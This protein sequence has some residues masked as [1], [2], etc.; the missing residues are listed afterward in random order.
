M[1]EKKLLY[2][3]FGEFAI[4]EAEARLEQ[5]GRPVELAPRAFQVL[6]EL[7]RRAGKLVT[8][9]ALL[10][11]VWGHRHVNEAALKNI[12]S[13]LRHALGDDAR[14]S[15]FIETVA[16]RGYRFIA[17]VTDTDTEPSLAVASV[18]PSDVGPASDNP[19]VGRGAV[20]ER[21]QAAVR[22][23]RSGQRQMVFVVGEA[24]I[25]KSALV[26]R[27]IRDAGLAVAFGQCIEHYGEA[28]PYMPVLEA[29]NNLCRTDEA[30]A[31]IDLMRRVAPTW[32]L[33]L[34][35]FV[36]D[37]DRKG[38][39]REGAGTTQD[40]MLREFGELID[41][42]TPERPLLM[43]LEDLQWSDHSTVQLLDYWAR[44][45]G[46][47]A[48]MVL[49]TFRPTELIFND[50]P[51]AA[52][53][54][55]LRQRRLSVD[56]E[57]EFLS[58]AEL[59]DYLA[60]RV[61][62][63]APES[64]VRQLHA[65]SSGLPLFVTAVVDEL[66]VSG[67]LGQIAGRW[68][69][70]DPDMAV[71]RSIAAVIEGQLH[72]LTPEQQRV[73]GAAS[74]G[75]LDFMHLTLAAA[76][77][78]D[79]ERV[80]AQVEDAAMRLPWLRGNGT[81][82]LEDGRPTARY[83]FTHAV[84]RQ[85]LYDQLSALQ[86][87]QWHRRWAVVLA[88]AHAASLPAVAAELALHF[89]RGDDPAQ[90]A[91]QLAV[92]AKRALACG[93]PRDALHTARHALALANG[94]MEL[95]LELELRVQEA[96]ALTRIEVIAAPEVASA[97]ERAR[98][99]DAFDC[100][101]YQSALQGCWWVAYSRAELGRARALAS[102]M[103]DIGMRRGDSA[104]R[105]A[106]L[107]AIGMIQMLTGEFDAA[108][109]SLGDA[110][111]IH[112]TLTTELPPTS[113][114]LDPGA[115]AA[116]ALAMV[117]WIVGEPRRAR[118][119]VTQA[120]SI[121]Q[122]H[123]HPLSEATALYAASVMHAWAG[124]F[125][126]VHALTERLHGILEIHALPESR[127]GFAWMHGRALVEL[128]RMD[129][130]LDE[131]MAGA[132]DAQDQGI[133]IGLCGFHYQFAMACRLAGREAQAAASIEAGLALSEEI[134]ETTMLAPLLLMRAQ[135]EMD[136]GAL[137]Q[138]S[139][140]LRQALATARAQGAALFELQALALAQKHDQNLADTSRLTQLLDLYRDDPSPL[141]AG[142]RATLG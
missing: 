59:S 40:R 22:A 27:V 80:L 130:G 20:L 57:L 105:L 67:K 71:P 58:E 101:A 68:Q 53:R 85:V 10:D 44:R 51:L 35:W 104:L 89:E 17:A 81:A 65:Q 131:M 77:G 122:A 13:Q 87:L 123:H 83:R 78:S 37:E 5:G 92:V 24:G 138:A 128:G 14:E 28:E 50:H 107:N 47:S 86:R 74:V 16:R 93:A 56:I 119:L 6:C 3:R 52:L 112:A 117:C 31:T 129:E 18:P 29:L 106:G 55:E 127:G 91:V 108:R 115:E 76:L 116:Q 64:Y 136:C 124:E 140:S 84:Y 62:H 125:E 75:G 70:P 23:A 99:L 126:T 96:V 41:R 61:G 54:L 94:R 30:G 15:V 73:L 133:H 2:A 45:R 42:L 69:T 34:P 100:P 121:A 110:L 109:R 114:M 1:D 111:D 132:R 118:Q 141:I 36:R 103:L 26:E 134:G 7:V 139:A 90:A 135:T 21:L 8:K 38:L 66:L 72:R 95:K 46:P 113:F 39:Q 82:T 79:A 43:V 9:D 88:A 48:A 25:G 63:P 33:Q 120:V 142:I 4:D 19:M 12:V 60:V 137:V 102:Q 49:G 32:L 98:A 11:A 97:F